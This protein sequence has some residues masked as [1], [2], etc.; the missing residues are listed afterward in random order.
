[1]RWLFDGSQTATE[2]PKN[3]KHTFNVAIAA[4]S[5]RRRV[6]DRA[7]RYAQPEGVAAQGR[8]GRRSSIA[9]PCAGVRGRVARAPTSSIYLSGRR[10]GLGRDQ[11][12]RNRDNCRLW[13]CPA[14]H[15]R[16]QGQ[17]GDGEGATEARRERQHTRRQ[18]R[19]VW[20]KCP[21]VGSALA[22][23]LRLPGVERYLAARHCQNGG[24]LSLH[25]APSHC[26]P[27]TRLAAAKAAHFTIPLTCQARPLS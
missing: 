2:C 3:W 12:D 11:G 21:R 23:L 20:S 25:W 14:P 27:N 1:M 8:G 26:L 22:R 18:R 5:R 7:R 4:C 10:A 17:R 24:R 6:V 16:G 9:E 15:R 19:D 13:L